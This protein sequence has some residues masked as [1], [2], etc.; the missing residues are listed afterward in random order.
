VPA[1][2]STSCERRKKKEEKDEE[3]KKA[4]MTQAASQTQLLPGKPGSSRDLC[5]V[6]PH[7]TDM[8]RLSEF[9]GS[10]LRTAGLS[11]CQYLQPLEKILL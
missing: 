2:S 11:V 4:P 8:P 7:R 10:G 6:D 9:P 3:T 5:L 1:F